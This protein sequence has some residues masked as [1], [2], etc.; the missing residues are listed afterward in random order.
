[1]S[2]GAKPGGYVRGLP[3]YIYVGTTTPVPR[4]RTQVF[5]AT[6]H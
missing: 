1:M 2:V 6:Y 4:I 3:L 5:L